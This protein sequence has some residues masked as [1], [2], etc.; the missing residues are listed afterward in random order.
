VGLNNDRGDIATA[1]ATTDQQWMCL[2]F[3]NYTTDQQWKKGTCAW[4]SAIPAGPL[5]AKPAGPLQDEEAVLL[6]EE[7]AAA[8]RRRRCNS[9]TI[10]I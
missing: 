9:D 7:D 8:P 3:C 6:H 10:C 5:H 1:C 2:V 4:R